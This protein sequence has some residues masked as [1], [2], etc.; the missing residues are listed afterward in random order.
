[1]LCLPG[2]WQ[3]LCEA[4]GMLRYAG[5]S[6]DTVRLRRMLTSAH[7][8]QQALWLSPL[9]PKAAEGEGSRQLAGMLSRVKWFQ[10][11]D[12]FRILNLVLY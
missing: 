2:R 5:R 7:F 1:M 6:P 3:F 8:C 10:Q 11:R 12:V 9:F 4:G